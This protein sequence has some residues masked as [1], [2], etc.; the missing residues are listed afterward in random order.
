MAITIT[1]QQIKSLVDA[2]NADYARG[3]KERAN[4]RIDSLPEEQRAPPLEKLYEKEAGN[5]AFMDLINKMREQLGPEETDKIVRHYVQFG[6][7]AW[8]AE[9][10]T[11][12]TPDAFYSVP[13]PKET[14]H[15]ITA[16]GWQMKGFP[17]GEDS[18]DI[19]KK[20]SPEERNWFLKKLNFPVVWT[21]PEEG[22]IGLRGRFP[23]QKKV[24]NAK[25]DMKNFLNQAKK[26]VERPQK[27]LVDKEKLIEDLAELLDEKCEQ[28][29]RYANDP[30][31]Q[32][33]EMGYASENAKDRG[34]AEIIKD[35][36]DDNVLQYIDRL[37]GRGVE[38]DEIR[39][40]LVETADEE[41]NDSYHR[42]S[43]AINSYP[44]SSEAEVYVEEPDRLDD[45]VQ[46]PK[47]PY[48]GDFNAN[49]ALLNED[50]IAQLEKS[51]NEGSLDCGW[52][53]SKH[54]YVLKRLS[55]YLSDQ[56]SI[57]TIVNPK[58]FILQ[59]SR[60]LKDLMMES[61]SSAERFPATQKILQRA[62]VES[63]RFPATDRVLR[64][65]P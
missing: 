59:A 7:E 29:E 1:P 65:K 62:C 64:K 26:I 52:D 53:E 14:L 51:V 45:W 12:P 49:L 17:K 54:Q 18:E 16:Y 5:Q 23:A 31:S 43:N 19:L 40:M 56:R 4:L 60:K 20:M 37:Q 10:E 39:D 47:W 34:L 24:F 55:V 44:L 21:D 57:E 22:N 13:A 63:D 28:E 9:P 41:F 3:K 15:P 38:D 25:F 58:K 46:D 48:P 6:K 27:G 11:E 2:L 42:T 50:D 36:D 8:N 32:S 30:E 61:E 33:D 35:I